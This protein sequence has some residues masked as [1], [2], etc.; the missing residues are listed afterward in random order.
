MTITLPASKPLYPWQDERRLRS[1]DR[2]WLLTDIE[3]YTSAMY[4]QSVP[5]RWYR[6]GGLD[7]ASMKLG[8]FTFSIDDV[9]AILKAGVT[10][11]PWKTPQPHGLDVTRQYHGPTQEGRFRETVTMIELDPELLAQGPSLRGYFVR[12]LQFRSNSQ[13][14]MWGEIERRAAEWRSIEKAALSLNGWF[15]AG[16]VKALVGEVN[17]TPVLAR[18]VEEGVLVPNGKRKRGARYMVAPAT[19][20]ERVDW[21]G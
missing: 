14:G 2:M 17:V 19:T 6:A 11:A 8:Y 1:G 16:D 21:A 5:Q 4:G 7:L 3:S 13:P 15:A 18:L 9:R 12:D 20:I 10:S